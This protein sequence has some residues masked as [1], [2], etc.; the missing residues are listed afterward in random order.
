MV[1]G[2]SLRFSRV[3]PV[4]RRDAARLDLIGELDLLLGLEEGQLREF[5]FSF[6]EVNAHLPCE[7]LLELFVQDGQI[8]HQEGLIEEFL[9]LL[10]VVKLY[11]NFVLLLLLEIA[12]LNF[13]LTLLCF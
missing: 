9:S 8:F 3:A 11:E 4:L 5:N 13:R 2:A 10:R 6:N 1:V 12:Y 7:H